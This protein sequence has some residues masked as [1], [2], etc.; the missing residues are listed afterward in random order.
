MLCLSNNKKERVSNGCIETRKESGKGLVEAIDRGAV[1]RA[2]HAVSGWRGRRHHDRVHRACEP[3]TDYA[4]AVFVALLRAG[5]EIVEHLQQA[6]TD[7][8]RLVR[9]SIPRVFE[10]EGERLREI[11][12]TRNR[13]HAREGRER[14]TR[15]GRGR[16]ALDLSN[17][18]VMLE[19]EPRVGV[20]TPVDDGESARRDPDSRLPPARRYGL[21]VDGRLNPLPAPEGTEEAEEEKR[22]SHESL[23]VQAASR[24]ERVV[25]AYLNTK[26]FTSSEVL[27]KRARR[28]RRSRIRGESRRFFLFKRAFE[29]PGSAEA[30]GH[31]HDLCWREWLVQHDPCE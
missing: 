14:G 1:T 16:D 11:M 8:A 13:V 7:P 21:A 25:V 19:R 28:R 9:I 24:L 30:H 31:A 29:V 5:G 26:A 23:E 10:G 3:D 6:E 20:V 2:P 4:L 15:L 17:R 12:V 22:I 18:R 27:K